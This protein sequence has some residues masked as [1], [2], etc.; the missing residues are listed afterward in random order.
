MFTEIKD[1]NE[2]YKNY[3][4]GEWVTSNNNES[5]TISSP[6]DDSIVANVTAIDKTG[7]D[8][9]I[10]AAKVAQ[11]KWNNVPINER[12]KIM[13]RVS[14]IL[15]EQSD[16]LAKM[17]LKEIAKDYKSGISEVERTAD[18]IRFSADVAKGIMGENLSSGNFPGFKDNKMSFVVREPLGVVLAIS[19]F[20]YPIN[21]SVSKVVPALMMGNSV[22]LKPATQGCISALMM[23]KLFEA[24]GLPKGLLNVVTGK[25]SEIGDYIVMHSGVDFINFTGSTK[26]GQRIAK[27]VTMKPLLM[28][29]GGKDAAIV[30]KDADL[31][32][33]VNNIVSG[34]YSYS[35]QRCTAVKRIL[36]VEE[37]ADAL[38]E[39]LTSKIKELKAG[40]PK[41]ED[42]TVV[43]LINESS[44]IFVESLIK[45]ALDKG[46][47]LKVGGTRVKNL[48][49]PTLID[50]VTTKMDLAWEEP[51]GPVLPIIRVKDVEEAIDI[52]NA[53]EYGLQSAVFTENINSAFQVAKRL[54]VGTIQINN[55]PERG[56]DHFPFLGVKSS[57]IGVQG[58]KYSMEAMSRPKA[59]VFN[60]NE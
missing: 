1:K 10:K 41:Q 13:Y 49:Q 6:V 30:L 60:I 56:P 59:I 3:I 51:F 5:I 20:N 58:I 27:Q 16:A 45:D 23:A 57:G 25:G 34:A 7:V 18:F 50:N 40:R 54:E 36:V 17:M 37:V 43:P 38:V 47:V 29:L 15:E 8:E 26:I 2:V 4:N 35:G 9:A 39:K 55:K 52:A 32:L 22:V 21:L 44:A 24:A 42:V 12:A 31:E 33:T 48:V 46:A 53:S 14:D 28:E 11:K 19:P